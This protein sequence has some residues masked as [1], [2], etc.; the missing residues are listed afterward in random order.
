MNQRLA[1]LSQGTSAFS[2]AMQ[3]VAVS[4]EEQS[5]TIGEIA[6]AATALTDGSGRITQLV[7]MFKLGGS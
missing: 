3:H 5:R 1:S 2:R 7:R 6:V 4:N